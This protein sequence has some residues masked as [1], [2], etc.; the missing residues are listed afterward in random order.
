M[1]N[2]CCP[3]SGLRGPLKVNRPP[4]EISRPVTVFLKYEGKKCGDLAPEA[5]KQQLLMGH[6]Y[7]RQH[8]TQCTVKRCDP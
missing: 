8:K 2:P 6:T 3:I 4:F 5:R 7:D 1:F